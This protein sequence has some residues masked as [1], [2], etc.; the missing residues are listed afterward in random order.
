MTKTIV[1]AQWL[2]L[3]LLVAAAIFLHGCQTFVPTTFNE[4]WV[5]TEGLVDEVVV[6]ATAAAKSRLITP[7]D[8]DNIATA[9]QVAKAGLIIAR[10]LNK[11][12]PYPA[13]IAPSLVRGVSCDNPTG[14]S[15]RLD[16]IRAGLLAWQDYLATRRLK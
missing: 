3:V 4:K 6:N 14:A 9:A 15:A 5:A 7:H 8:V 10:N 2:A 11:P 16:A 1:S 12:C 13:S